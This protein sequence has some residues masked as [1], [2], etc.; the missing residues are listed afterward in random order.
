MNPDSPIFWVVAFGS[1]LVVAWG[2]TVFA[3]WCIRSPAVPQAKLGRLRA[4]ITV[5]EVRELLGEPNTI[6]DHNGQPLWRYGHRLKRHS[7]RIRF[8]DHGRMT[9]FKHVFQ[10]EPQDR[11]V[12]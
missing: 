1:L 5:Q 9:E 11:E 6:R 3:R 4:G 12:T 7:L 10:A 8:D 2:F